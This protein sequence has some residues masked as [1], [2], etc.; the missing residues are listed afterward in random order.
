MVTSWL[1]IE[2]RNFKFATN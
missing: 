2:N 1:C